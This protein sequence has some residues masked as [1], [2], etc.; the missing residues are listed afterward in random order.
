MSQSEDYRPVFRRLSDDEGGGWLVEFPDLS[1]CMADGETLEEAL[2]QAR[3]A[4]AA[5]LDAAKA[6]GREIPPPSTGEAA[7]SGKWVQR[8]PKSLHARLAERARD[9]GVSLNMLVTTF[10]ADALARRE[11][12]S[13]DRRGAADTGSSTST[14]SR[15][16]RVAGRTG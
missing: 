7:Y 3:D 5:W 1:G 12:R 4:V 14:S 11:E 10:L 2:A 16:I 15:E 6:E 8:V 9:E 13:G